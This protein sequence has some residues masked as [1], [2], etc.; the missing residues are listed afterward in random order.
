MVSGSGSGHRVPRSDRRLGSRRQHGFLDGF[1]LSHD[2]GNWI[3]FVPWPLSVFVPRAKV[4]HY[5][6]DLTHVT[7]GPKAKFLHSFGFHRDRPHELARALLGHVSWDGF[8]DIQAFPEGL[9]YRFKGRLQIGAI[10]GPVVRTVWQLDH[11]SP[12]AHFIT[13]TPA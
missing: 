3:G 9:R 4:T 13:M 8:H 7:G 6:L 11:G 1:E 10:D 2:F 5:L 12:C